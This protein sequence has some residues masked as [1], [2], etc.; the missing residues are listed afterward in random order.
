MAGYPFPHRAEEKNNEKIL[1]RVAD[2]ARDIDPRL[3][4]LGM[5]SL[6]LAE[7]AFLA[8]RRMAGKKIMAGGLRHR[9]MAFLPEA[10][11]DL[12]ILD[13]EH[14]KISVIRPGLDL[15]GAHGMANGWDDALAQRLSMAFSERHGYL[16]AD[17]SGMGTGLRASV[18]LF[19]PGLVSGE[20]MNPIIRAVH[21][22]R[23]GIGGFF[24][25]GSSP[26]GC[27]FQIYN[28][29]TLG[30]TEAAIIRRMGALAETIGEQELAAREELVTK[31]SEVW[32]DRISRVM[33]LLAHARSVSMTEGLTLLS[34]ARL[35]AQLELVPVEFLP[36]IDGLM[37]ALLPAHLQMGYGAWVSEK[38][39]EVMRAEYL[40][41]MF[42]EVHIRG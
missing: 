16:T 37:V 23:S 4:F 31:S 42:G 19:L 36:Q 27:M 3:Q 12:R 5:D 14:V 41:K 32:L 24:G 11:V 33:A 20:K 35:A 13:G 28:Q 26:E 22:V 2:A 38:R 6:T 39:Q 34:Q 18:M 29:Q 21:A 1:H 30:E 9:G 40:R 7:R 8:E 15:E 10:G 17:P 25:M